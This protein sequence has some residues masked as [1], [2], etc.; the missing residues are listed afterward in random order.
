MK[1]LKLF[2]TNNN[3]VKVTIVDFGGV[4]ACYVDGTLEFYG[5]YYHDKIADKIKGFILGLE[6]IKKSYIYNLFVEV[7]KL[8][9]SEDMYFHVSEMGNVPPKNLKDVQL[10]ED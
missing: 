7:E 3:S 10:S 2:E 9:A 8:R 1:Y 5:D 6:Y 4:D